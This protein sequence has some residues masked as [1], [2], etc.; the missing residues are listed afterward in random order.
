MRA[1]SIRQPYV[2]QILRGTK[3]IE[4]RSRSTQIRGRF[5]LYASRS[6]GPI[7]E[8]ESLGV[9]PGDLPTGVIVGTA[10]LVDCTKGGRFYEWHLRDPRRLARPRRPANHPQPAWFNPF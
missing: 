9:E 2:E 8:F 10:E 5:Y 4:Y 3:R 7:D 6:P 1:L